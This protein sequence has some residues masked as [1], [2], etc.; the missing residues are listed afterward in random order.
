MAVARI[1]HDKAICFKNEL[2]E[3]HRVIRV[4]EATKDEWRA[5]Q[6]SDN[7]ALKSKCCEW[8]EGSIYIVEFPLSL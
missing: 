8:I 1:N 3:S 6:G 7:Q 4:C 5:Y 2:N